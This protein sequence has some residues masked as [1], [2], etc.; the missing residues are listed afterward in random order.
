MR[1]M[2]ISAVSW[3]QTSTSR[4]VASANWSMA[5]ARLLRILP[6]GSAS[7]SAWSRVFGSTSS[8]HTTCEWPIGNCVRKSPVAFGSLIPKPHSGQIGRSAQG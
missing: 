7:S 1:P 8:P 5:S 6:C 3:R 2:G 4:Q